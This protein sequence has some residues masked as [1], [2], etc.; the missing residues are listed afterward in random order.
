MKRKVF[1]WNLK[2]LQVLF[3]QQQVVDWLKFG[4]RPGNL[5]IFVNLSEERF[6]LRFLHEDIFVTEKNQLTLKMKTNY[7]RIKIN[8]EKEI[9]FEHY[10]RNF[11][12]INDILNEL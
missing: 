11:K 4:I 12:F 6:D 2:I 9:T 7:E 5:A 10:K 3:Q 8:S 1:L